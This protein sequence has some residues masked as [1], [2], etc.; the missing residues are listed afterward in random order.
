MATNRIGY[1]VSLVGLEWVQGF[2]YDGMVAGSRTVPINAFQVE[3]DLLSFRTR[4]AGVCQ[5]GS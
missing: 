1:R 2:V 4:T 3:S 5:I